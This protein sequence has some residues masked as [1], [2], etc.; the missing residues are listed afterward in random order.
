MFLQFCYTSRLYCI[1]HFKHHVSG[2]GQYLTRGPGQEDTHT[3]ACSFLPISA[4]CLALECSGGQKTRESPGDCWPHVILCFPACPVLSPCC[5]G[6]RSGSPC[7][8]SSPDP[9]S[10]SQTQPPVS[11]LPQPFLLPAFQ[12]KPHLAEMR[13]EEKGL[14]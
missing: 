3:V 6:G 12:P 11:G 8:T 4:A 5:A 9:S 1:H 2:F 10:S 13:L 7:T 14:E